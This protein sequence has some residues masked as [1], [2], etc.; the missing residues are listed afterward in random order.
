ME[1]GSEINVWTGV[2]ITALKIQMFSSSHK[3]NN[4]TTT[5]LKSH[6]ADN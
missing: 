4:Q 2:W 3:N 5:L 1:Y 6:K